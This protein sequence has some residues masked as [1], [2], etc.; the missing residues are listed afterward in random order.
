MVRVDF[1]VVYTAQGFEE[2]DFTSSFTNRR[3]A[4]YVWDR[5]SRQFV[6]SENRS[7]ISEHEMNLVANV[8]TEEPDEEDGV[9]IGGSTF[10][11]GLKGF[12][13]SGFEMFLRLNSRR[14]MKIAKGSDSR[15][16]EWLRT[17]M[18]QCDEI[19]EK[20]ALENALRAQLPHSQKQR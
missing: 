20:L 11:S 9:T 12:V 4:Y 16:K 13:G 19:P 15:S 5:R 18:K 6:F 7:T 1:V 10:Y 14:L 2:A 8:E 17:F 3:H